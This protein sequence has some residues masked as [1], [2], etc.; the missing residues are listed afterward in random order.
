[1]Y[2]SRF[3]AVTEPP[4]L[5]KGLHVID[6]CNSSISLAWEEPDQGDLPSGYILEMRAEDTKEWT[7]CTKIPISGTIYTVGGLQERQKY[8]FRIR[9][10]NEGG[11]GEPVELEKGVFAMPPPGNSSAVF[12]AAHHFICDSVHLF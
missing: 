5:V 11:V 12:Q 7:K 4:G 1:M 8:F 6:S 2:K 10:V 9:A 3:V